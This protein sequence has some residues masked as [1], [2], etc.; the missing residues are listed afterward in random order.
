VDRQTPIFSKTFD[1]TSWLLQVTEH[2]P[3]SQR[4]VVT[5]RML[6]ASLDFQ[7][8]LV[9]ANAL[10]GAKRAERLQQADAALVKMRL[11]LRLAVRFE[12]LSTGQYEHGS[13]MVVEVGRL[14]GGWMK[15]ERQSASV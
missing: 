11:Y 7:E 4:F 13:R 1:L 12:W 6:D 5:K 14:L 8:L 10:R 2:F 3:R 9:E 15:T